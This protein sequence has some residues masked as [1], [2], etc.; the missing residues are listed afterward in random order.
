M[1]SGERSSSPTHNET[2]DHIA[3]C[4]IRHN[5]SG[6]SNRSEGVVGYVFKKNKM[7]G[8]TKLKLIASK[9]KVEIVYDHD[10]MF[11]AKIIE[12]DGGVRGEIKAKSFSELMA[13][14]Y[15]EYIVRKK[16]DNFQYYRGKQE[17]KI[18]G[19]EVSQA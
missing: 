12:A 17:N 19:Y 2:L 4:N 10:E 15:S 16:S 8:S 1:K 13:K 9:Y 6:E 14:C 11:V 18:Y 3:E 7:R 5:G